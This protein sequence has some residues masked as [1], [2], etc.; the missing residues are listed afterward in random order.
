MEMP[1]GGLKPATVPK[2]HT[3]KVEPGTQ[4]PPPGTWDLRESCINVR[5]PKYGSRVMCK[6]IGSR[7]PH[8]GSWVPGKES[9]WRVPG[10]GSHVKVLG[11]AYW[12]RVPGEGSQLEGPGSRVPL[13]R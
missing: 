7:F 2:G 12:S 8:I 13:F 3:G 10:P 4:D 1:S 11:P 5:V 6:G 9:S